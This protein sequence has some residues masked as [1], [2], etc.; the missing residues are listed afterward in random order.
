MRLFG[1]R[2]YDATSVADIERAAGLTPGAGGLFHHF[3]SK[4]EVLGAGIGRQL[5]RLDALR[6]IRGA[7][8]PLGD[9]RAELTLLARY[10]LGEMAAEREMLFAEARHRPELLGE[11]VE[12][13]V[14]DSFREF[15]QWLRRVAPASGSSP[16]VVAAVGLG[17]IGYYRAAEALLDRP[18]VEVDEDEF[19]E[20][21]VDM[22]AG[23]LER[24]QTPQPGA[25]GRS[26]S[27][28]AEA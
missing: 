4:E 7:V 10:V 2:G 16:D 1:E 28:S 27:S 8:P 23:L 17:A 14:R 11:A 13:I 19:I 3:R 9:L 24:D 20:T 22:V 6:Q 25:K 5:D 15:S 12:R 21:W 18:P 26:P